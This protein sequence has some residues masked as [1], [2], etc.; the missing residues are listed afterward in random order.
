MRCISILK[1]C[2]QHGTDLVRITRAV[3]G[4][5]NGGSA[6]REERN[7]YTTS[8]DYGGALEEESDNVGGMRRLSTLTRWMSRSLIAVSGSL[9]RA[10]ERTALR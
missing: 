10:E 9:G 1:S 8:E 6:D 3:V 2:S 7:A 4:R 5:A